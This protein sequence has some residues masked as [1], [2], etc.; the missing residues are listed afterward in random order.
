MRDQYQ[1][2][3]DDP[4]T[5]DRPSCE[6]RHDADAGSYGA[7][8]PDRGNTAIYT[9]GMYTRKDSKMLMVIVSRKEIGVLRRIV[10]E[11][12]PKAFVII[13]EVKDVLGEGFVEDY[14]SAIF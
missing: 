7:K 8:T 1:V 11:I 12:D 2:P 5:N 10:H 14:T 4:S 9:Q 13:S 3:F 6:S